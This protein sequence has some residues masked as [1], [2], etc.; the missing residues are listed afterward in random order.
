MLGPVARRAGTRHAISADD[1]QDH[2]DRGNRGAGRP[3]RR[4]TTGRESR[5]REA[6]RT[7][8]PAAMPSAT[9]VMPCL[10]IS[11]SSCDRFAP[12]AIRMPISLRRRAT[13]YDDHA[14]DAEAG[15]QQRRRG[16]D[17]HQRRLKSPLLDRRHRPGP[18]WRGSARSAVADPRCAARRESAPA[19]VSGPEL[20][21]TTIDDVTGHALPVRV[22]GVRRRIVV[23][24]G[25]HV[26][27][28]ADQRLHLIVFA[29]ELAADGIGL[30][31]PQ[32]LRR[33][34]REHRDAAAA[35]AFV[36]RPPMEDGDVHRAEISGAREPV[37]DRV[38]LAARCRSRSR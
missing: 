15:D 3:P 8:I 24:R 30:A 1:E 34:H 5:A 32:Q 28:D 27:D 10:T 38:A 17:H 2:C 23:Q 31:R 26:G 25:A 16:E 18:A 7:T 33:L 37:V 22:I 14:V 20:V 11:S 35:I 13:E 36:E 4:R 19:I 9:G 29:H 6:A 21:R 12:S